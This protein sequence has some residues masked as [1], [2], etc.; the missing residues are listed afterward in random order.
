LEKTSSK[1]IRIEIKIRTKDFIKLKN[2]ITAKE[3]IIRVKGKN[4]GKILK[5]ICFTRNYYPECPRNSNSSA[6]RKP[7]IPLKNR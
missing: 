7:I 3:T 5:I 4:G 6:A 2:F 1:T